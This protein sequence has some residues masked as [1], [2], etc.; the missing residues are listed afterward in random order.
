MHLGSIKTGRRHCRDAIHS[1]NSTSDEYVFF[2]SLSLEF[3][4][5]SSVIIIIKFV[6]QLL[7]TP[8]IL[9]F[10][11]KFEFEIVDDAKMQAQ[12]CALK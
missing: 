11:E 2:F 8:K 1:N 5:I 4:L 9:L 6:P 3:I 12:A 10:R 7:R